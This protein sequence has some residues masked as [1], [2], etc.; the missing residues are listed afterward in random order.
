M[1]IVTLILSLPISGKRRLSMIAKQSDDHKKHSMNLAGLSITFGARSY[2][3]HQKLTSWSV[4]DNKD[5]EREDE[6]SK[7]ARVW[8]A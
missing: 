8:E 2:Q 5:F 7:E 1:T 6:Q 4:V 3:L